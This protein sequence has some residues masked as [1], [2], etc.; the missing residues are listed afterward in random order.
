MDELVYNENIGIE[1]TLTNGTGDI[2]K[3][4]EMTQFDIMDNNLFTDS[5]NVDIITQLELA[6]EIQGGATSTV[7]PQIISIVVDWNDILTQDEA[8]NDRVITVNTRNIED[9]QTVNVSFDNNTYSSKV[10]SHFAYVTIPSSAFQNI[11]FDGSTHYIYADATNKNGYPAATNRISVI[12]GSTTQEDVNNVNNIREQQQPSSS[13]PV[14]NI[15]FLGNTIINT[16]QG[17]CKIKNIS[18]K[19]TIRKEP[20]K[21]VTKT[22]LFDKHFICFEKDSLC[23][24]VPNEKM[25][26]SKNHEV[27]FNGTWKRAFEYVDGH[28]I[29]KVKYNKEPMYNILF[30]K[31]GVLIVNNM[32]CESLHPENAIAKLYNIMDTLPLD[33]KEQ[34]IKKFNQ[35]VNEEI[36]KSKKSKSN[37]CIKI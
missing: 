31:H 7:M 6:H 23:K 10:K 8:K 35:A 3:D 1:S 28:N 30:E 17:L 37:V 26:I 36:I 16:D 13:T 12:I 15:C 22:I 4:L 29:Y 24:N 9:E 2:I 20:I 25:C 5:T 19:H 14:Y 18:N 34:L 33:N 11:L 32:I 27:F 21:H